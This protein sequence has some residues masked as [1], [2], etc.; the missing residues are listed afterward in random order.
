MKKIIGIY[1]DSEFNIDSFETG[2]GGSET[3]VLQLSKEFI[4]RNYHVIIICH[5]PWYLYENDNLEFFP[6]SQFFSRI[7]YQHFDYFIFTRCIYDDIYFKLIENNCKNIYL[8]SHDMFVW[9]D[10]LYENKYDYNLNNYTYIKKFVALTKF[11]K[12][13]LMT[14]NNIP[15][16]KIEIIGNGLDSTTFDNV[17]KLYIE[18]DN[19]ILW[20]SAFGRG[21]DILVKHILPIVKREIPDFKINICGYSDNIPQE[22]KNNSD[23]NFLGTLTKED[24]YKE[25]KKHK[26]WFLPCVVVEDF[27]I[28]AAEAVMCGNHIVSPYLHGMEDVLS[29]FTPFAIKHKYKTKQ[30]SNYH[31]S[32]YELDMSDEEFQNTNN[33]VAN[34]II[35]TIRNYDNPFM[36][37]LLE[38]QKKYVTERFTWKNIADKWIN[39]FENK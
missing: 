17:D 10:N 39:I 27:G 28:C 31:Y 16:D 34:A 3:W 25:F 18:K 12:W 13:E 30:T 9:K 35:D 24:Y 36:K 20:T 15:K 11:H 23:V 26:V 4:K 14:Y 5:A 1:Y 37:K 38:S 19:E 2:C 21:G 6:I 8:Q 33:E 7:N 29:P 22:I 32:K